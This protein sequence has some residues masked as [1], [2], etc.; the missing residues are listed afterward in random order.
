[1]REKAK[2][3]FNLPMKGGE[4]DVLETLDDIR[5][6]NITVEQAVLIKQ[7]QAAMNGN[8]DAA[9]FL[10]NVIGEESD[11][12]DDTAIS[13]AAKAG[14]TLAMLKALRDKLSTLADRSTNVREV[15]SITRQ[16]IEVNDRIDE[17]EKNQQNKQG[18]NPL[19]IILFN[20]AQKRAKKVAGA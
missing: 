4:L 9:M 6:A 15:A 11:E 19:N 10:Q 5:G 3:L 17:I 13:E 18:E 20:S 8:T 16:L 12:C 2:E 14:D 1:M 7:M